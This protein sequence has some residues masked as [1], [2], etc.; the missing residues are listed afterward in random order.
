M[1]FIIFQGFL[2]AK[3]YSDILTI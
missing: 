3:S 1:Y 2:K